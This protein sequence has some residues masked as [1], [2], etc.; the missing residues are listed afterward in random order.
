[1][2]P[3]PPLL[4]ATENKPRC[5][6]PARRRTSSFAARPDYVENSLLRAQASSTEPHIDIDGVGKRNFT[7]RGRRR[8]ESRG[9]RVVLPLLPTPG[10]GVRRPVVRSESLLWGF[11]ERDFAVRLSVFEVPI[12]FKV[13]SLPLCADDRRRLELAPAESTSNAMMAS[14]YGQ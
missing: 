11:T 3:R 5:I 7:R 6:G 2:P 8:S 14:C 9:R 13:D 1:M 4:G 12:G 10:M